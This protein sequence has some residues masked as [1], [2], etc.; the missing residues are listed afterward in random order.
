MISVSESVIK[1]QYCSICVY[2]S[3]FVCGIS[4]SYDATFQ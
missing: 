1:I 2:A 4:A 3:G